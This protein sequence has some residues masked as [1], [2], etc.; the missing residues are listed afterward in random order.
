MDPDFLSYLIDRYG[1]ALTL[2]AR[3]WC[4][5]ADDVVQESFM[6]LVRQNPLPTQP[7]PWLYRVVRNAS[8][9]QHRAEKRRQ[10]H[11]TKAAQRA[12]AWFLPAD[13]PAGLDAVRATQSLGELP[14]EQREI[15][16]AHLWGGLTFEQISDVVGGSAATVWR[17]Y[18]AGLQQ[19]RHIL[20]V[21]QE[22]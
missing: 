11:E 4:N 14:I 21:S 6:K 20:Q 1:P 19:L 9:S 17:R 3:Q 16:V 10:N 8:I 18:S 5:A 22:D 7:I 13:D 15:I 12:G 2:Y